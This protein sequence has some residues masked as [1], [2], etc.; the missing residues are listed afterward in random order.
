MVI[1][2]ITGG[3]IARGNWANLM[4]LIKQFVK[5]CL[6]QS[7]G[8]FYVY[9]ILHILYIFLFRKSFFRLGRGECHKPKK[10]TLS[11]KVK[12]RMVIENNYGECRKN[13]DRE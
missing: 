12:G 11:K 2:S 5:L 13:E 9:Y 1:K 10:K 4:F 6:L 7:K 3:Q 8:L